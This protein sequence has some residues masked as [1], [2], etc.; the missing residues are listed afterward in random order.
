MW[1][2]FCCRLIVQGQKCVVVFPAANAAA[3]D[4]HD[5]LRGAGQSIPTFREYLE[6]TVRNVLLAGHFLR[7]LHGRNEALL[8]L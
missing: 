7:E 3:A 1:G 6:I 8:E 4:R 5:G 2:S